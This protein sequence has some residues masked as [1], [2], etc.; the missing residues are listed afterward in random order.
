MYNICI[1]YVHPGHVR[2]E[3]MDSFTRTISDGRYKTSIIHMGA[4]VNIQGARN[5]C[6]R[7]FLKTT[8][9]YLLIVDT[10]MVWE[11]SVPELLIKKDVPIVS[12]F[13]LGRHEDGK[14][15]PV[16]TMWTTPYKLDAS[17][18]SGQVMRELV[19]DDLKEPLV[20]VAGV[21][22]GCC[23]IRRDVCEALGPLKGEHPEGW[24]FAVGQMDI[25]GGLIF[26]GEDIAFCVRAFQLGYSSYVAADVGIGH[27][28]HF[29]MMPPLFGE[30]NRKVTLTAKP[31]REGV[32]VKES[33][34]KPLE[35][36]SAP[37]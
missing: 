22:M 32:W 37:V 17:D 2:H 5:T 7:Q 33:G 20:E 23:L 19:M 3:F 21:G 12:G 4:G 14:A 29:I 30:E 31:R 9:D 16:G 34:V 6:F 15:F 25:P 18:N 11:P 27:V 36:G 26:L 10:D 13:Y 8:D 24:P 28:K 1:T 35:L